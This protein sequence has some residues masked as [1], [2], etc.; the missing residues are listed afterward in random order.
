MRAAAALTREIIQHRD[1]RIEVLSQGDGPPIV[2]LPSLGRVRKISIGS[3]S[4]W[5]RPAIA[6]CGRSRAASV[7]ATD[8]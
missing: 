6:C 4:G 3:R 7:E 8:R 2:L 1:G 5:R